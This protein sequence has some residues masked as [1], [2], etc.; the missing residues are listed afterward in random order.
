MVPSGLCT[1]LSENVTCV[2]GKLAHRRVKGSE[3]AGPAGTPATHFDHDRK[4]KWL[5]D[6]KIDSD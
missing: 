3:A 1:A 2:R 6:G 5:M 4:T